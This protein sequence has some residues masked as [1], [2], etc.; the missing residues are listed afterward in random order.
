MSTPEPPV[1]LNPTLAESGA[2]ISA[3]N[4]FGD[5]SVSASTPPALHGWQALQ[6]AVGQTLA[7]RLDQS[8]RHRA[9]A[10]GALARG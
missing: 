5:L 2:G 3:S 6:V 4:P 1:D 8:R 10:W 9:A 7:E